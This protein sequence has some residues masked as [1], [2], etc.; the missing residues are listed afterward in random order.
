MELIIN[1]DKPETKLE[2]GDIVNIYLNIDGKFVSFLVCREKDDFVL[3]NLNGRD[4]YSRRN[5]IES[6][7][8]SIR[9]TNHTHYSSK[10]YKLTLQLI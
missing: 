5:S 10:Y 4:C 3:R 9:D 8:N 2:L 1:K 6:L 7:S